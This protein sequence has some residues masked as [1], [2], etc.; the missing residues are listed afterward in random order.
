VR[1]ELK[2][3]FEVLD[4]CLERCDTFLTGKVTFVRVISFRIEQLK[5]KVTLFKNI[6]KR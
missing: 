2:A 4:L 5:N 6:V 1:K 3:R